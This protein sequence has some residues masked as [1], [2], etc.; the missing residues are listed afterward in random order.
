[1]KTV[2]AISLGPSEDNYDFQTRFMG[3]D[4]HLLRI[5]T[6]GDN[7]RAADLMM[8]WDTKAD[9]IGLGYIDFPYSIGSKSNIRQQARKFA[10][11]GS[12]LRTP[13]ATGEALRIVCHE[14]TLRHL[15][16]VNG[17]NFFDNNRVLFTSGL[18]N[19]NM[20]KV[21]SEYT[22][23]LKF[24]DPILVNGI[25]KFINSLDDLQ[26]YAKGIHPVLQWVPSKKFSEFVSPVSSCND[27]LIRRAMQ[28]S[29]I[30][31]VPY[32][33][34]YQH[35]E[36]YGLKELGGKIVITATAYE[37]RVQFLK[38]R[39]VR[40]I[41][42]TTPKML[43][44]VVG[45]SI[46]EAMIM[47]ALGKN[48]KTLLQDDLLEV[49]T[50]LRMNPRVIYP[51]GEKKRINRFA[52]VVHPLSQDFL[53]KIKPVG[54]ISK[55]APRKTMKTLE[56]LIAYS[57]PFV[58]SKINGIKSPEGV[59]AEGWLIAI[60]A[61]PRQ[62]LAHSPDFTN[63]RLLK[64]AS[65]AKKLGAQILGL[66][67]LTKAMGDAGVTVAKFSEIPVTTGNSYSASAALWA[68]AEAVRQIGLLRKT[69]GKKLKGKTMVIG[70]TGAVGAVCSKLL[71][72]AFDEVY[73]V[74]VHNAK[75]LSVK[76]SIESELPD[77]KIYVTTRQDKYISE[78]DVIVTASSKAGKPILD[79]MK[80][81]PGCVITDVN[82]PLN[83][84][85]KDLKLRPDV[86][87]IASG[88]ITLPGEP[89]M[90]DIGLPPGVA[91]ASLAEAIVLAMEGRFENFSVGRDIKWEKVSEIY[92]LG[93][94]HGMKLAGITG[95]QG[96]ITDEDFTRVREL[97]LAARKEKLAAVPPVPPVPSGEPLPKPTVVKVS[98]PKAKKV[99]KSEEKGKKGPDAGA[100]PMPEPPVPEPP[101]S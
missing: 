97:A 98:K 46:L 45:L 79:I 5:G 49:I 33:R 95:I 94:K 87:I 38:E 10:E 63:D 28:Q 75:L 30:I 57:P 99:K 22:T 48:Q 84:T 52:F 39:G 70:A 90:R 100:V 64:A 24:C 6:D 54:F 35:L 89:E 93:L 71:A 34:F 56:K 32:H 80:V 61:T 40:M 41:I 88:E 65:M 18:M 21:F 44:K 58:Y 51:F 16:H 36:N 31:V 37:D 47:L 26:L 20:A 9:A 1:M 53:K 62:M 23:N 13:F 29:H 85:A 55:F 8:E 72:T 76:E 67:A 96:A 82:R 73:M 2:A 68:A 4:F 15:Q 3:Q 14:W 50:E 101:V 42:D 43:E 86:L 91:Y 92:K 83:F 7:D 78:M 11:L 60:G 69:R 19:A 77:A 17:N 66:G 59:E 12:R 74:D 25:P 27:F 81:K